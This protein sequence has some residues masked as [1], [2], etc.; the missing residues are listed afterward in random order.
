M[1]QAGTVFK[2]P[3]EETILL[4]AY[5]E[6]RTNNYTGTILTNCEDMDVFIQTGYGLHQ[7][8]GDLLINCKHAFI[9]WCAMLTQEVVNIIIPLHVITGSAHTLGFYGQGEKRFREGNV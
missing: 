9:N 6:L 8:Q 3:E 2:H 7:L 4:S 5:A 1:W